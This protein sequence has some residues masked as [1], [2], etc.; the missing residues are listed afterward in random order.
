MQLLG[1]HNLWNISAIVALADV[2]HIDDEVLQQT[3]K[4]FQ[5]V[6]HRLQKV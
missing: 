6:R 1:E 4:E 3:V 2:L 5:P